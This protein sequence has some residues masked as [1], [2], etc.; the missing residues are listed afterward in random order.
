M[1]KLIIGLVVIAVFV[2]IGTKIFQKKGTSKEILSISN[3]TELFPTKETTQKYNISGKKQAV[4]T[5]VESK[6]GST[7]VTMSYQENKETVER[8]YTMN[9][10]KILEEV[11]HLSDGKEVSTEGV[12]EILTSFPYVGLTYHSV[13]GLITYEVTEMNNNKITIISTQK[14]TDYEKDKPVERDYKIKR[15]FEKGKGMVLYETEL[16]GQKNTVLKIK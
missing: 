16:N 5:T 8:I 1:K 13:D 7:I 12:T 3:Y 6:D 15:I 14:I 11:K 9:S 2:L 4:K 10:E